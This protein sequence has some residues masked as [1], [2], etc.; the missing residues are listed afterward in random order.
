MANEFHELIELLM[1]CTEPSANAAVDSTGVV[2][3]EEI[4]GMLPRRNRLG[5]KAT[6]V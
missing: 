6:V 2:A 5:L 1:K 4:G 3:F